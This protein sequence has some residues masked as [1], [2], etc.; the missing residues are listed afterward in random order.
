MAA[1]WTIQDIPD[2][3][4]R[5]AV[6]TGS[7]SGIGLEIARILASNG[8][9]VLMACRSKDK[10]EAAA[11]GIRDRITK[12]SVEFVSLDLASLASIDAASSSLCANE[13]SLDLLVNNAGLMALDLAFTEDG[14]EMQFGVNHLGHFAFTAGL[15]PL[16]LATPG[17]RIVTMSSQGHRAGRMNLDD[18]MYQKRTY[19]RW[20]AYSQS[21]LANLLF[22]LELQR[23]LG[24]NSP[25]Q[26]LAAHPGMSHTDLGFEGSSFSNRFLRRA[27]PYFT[28]SAASGALPAVRAGTDPGASGGE[29]YGP[30]FMAAGPPV[31]ETPSGR[32]RNIDDAKHLWELSEQ[33]TARK[34][35]TS[36]G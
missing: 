34:F 26:S 17:S 27:V 24:S 7:N 2:L 4:G 23:R 14:F 3:S 19:R 16:L 12:G 25:T 35:V 30:M 31:K 32:A 28:Q 6:V 8:A 29:Y 9:R 21:K 18:P 20:M 10:A 13:S 22:A 5:T 33:L 15:M 36:L 1:K 11:S